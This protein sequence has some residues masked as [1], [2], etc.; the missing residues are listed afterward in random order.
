[1]MGGASLMEAGLTCQSFLLIPR[2]MRID[3]VQEQVFWAQVRD[4]GVR[5]MKMLG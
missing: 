1:M 4:S 3:L 2:G 5:E